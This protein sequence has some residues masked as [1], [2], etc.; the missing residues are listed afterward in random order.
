MNRHLLRPIGMLALLAVV[1]LLAACTRER[2]PLEHRASAALTPPTVIADWIIQGRNDFM[3]F[4]LRSEA[5]FAAGHLPQAV[6]VEPAKLQEPGVVRALPG[7]KKLVFYAEGDVGADTLAPLFQRGLH[8]M[9]V[10]GGY[11]GW[12]RQVLSKPEQVATPQEAKRD[13]VA[14]YFRGESALGTPKPLE[15]ISAEQY[16]RPPQLPAAAPAPTYESEG[17]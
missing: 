9:I 4:D 3:L 11:E 2:V 12:E 5:A 15:E 13:A 7:Y 14:R 1:A 10:D 17:C 16:L 6:R 8:V